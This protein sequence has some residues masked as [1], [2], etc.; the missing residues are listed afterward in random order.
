MTAL[1]R[2]DFDSLVN[3]AMAEPGR[4]HM[5]PVI[6]KELL[7]YDIL[8]ALDVNGLLD[9]LTF[10]GGTAL[11][12]IYGGS[13]FSEDLDFAGGVDFDQRKLSEIKDC[14]MDYVGARYGLVAQVKSPKD[15]ALEAVNR[16]L[17]VCKWQLSVQTAP[18]RP[19]L[20]RQRIKLEVANIPAYTR[21]PL[22]LQ[23]NYPWLP[24]GYTQTLVQTETLDEILADKLVS[25][26]NCNYVRHRD[27]W[28]IAWLTQAPRSAGVRGDL[29]NRKL[30]DYSVSDYIAKLDN[31]AGRLP[32]IFAGKECQGSL[33]RFLPMDTVARTLDQD[34]FGQY[35]VSS[36]RK[37]L[38]EAR[39][40]HLGK[41]P[42]PEFAM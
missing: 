30:G 15:V 27:I 1:D 4:A 39:E 9:E 20:P 6:E 14:L 16:G 3:R 32:E 11:R 38:G 25:L 22:P 12:L 8:Y 28:D 33:R 37:A 5:R 31:I 34:K 41:A 26:P 29:I 19:D 17:N 35:L 36:V 24:E 23:L 42:A 21:E 10:Q 40:C 13:R 18:D 2:A 7:H